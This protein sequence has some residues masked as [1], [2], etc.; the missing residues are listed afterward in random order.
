MS[1]IEKHP[2]IKEFLEFS[3]YEREEGDDDD[4]FLDSLVRA[5]DDKP[6]DEWNE[7]LT[8]EAQ[9]FSNLCVNRIKKGKSLPDLPDAKTKETKKVAKDK[10][11]KTKDKKAKSDGNTDDKTDKKAKKSS[12]GATK[13]T[14]SPKD[15]F[16]LR[17]GSKASDAAAMF[18]E[19]A[20]MADV[21]KATGGSHYN[22]LSKLKKLGH[23]VD[24]G[25]DHIIT[26]TAAD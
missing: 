11:S 15:K 24:T 4:E 12:N 2:I 21:K 1:D 14:A 10:K 6:E 7:S 9:A 22:L 26:I 17:E 18:E 13:R 3:G 23:E 5:V 20:K 16:G 25:D 8:D 19:G